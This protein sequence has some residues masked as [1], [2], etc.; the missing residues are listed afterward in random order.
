MTNGDISRIPRITESMFD[1]WA[2]NQ[3]LDA[4][5]SALAHSFAQLIH[6]MHEA[7]KCSCGL[8]SPTEGETN[9]LLRAAKLPP[10]LSIDEAIFRRLAD[11]PAEGIKYYF[12]HI[13]FIESAVRL[14]QSDLARRPRTRRPITQM[15]DDIVEAH[16]SIS[17][18][19]VTRA[20]ASR[21]GV[22]VDGSTFRLEDG[23]RCDSIEEKNIASR[24]SDAKKRLKNSG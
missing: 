8:V 2:S 1:E 14:R 10:P 24:V 21:C 11:N 4:S 18:K 20:L 19:D 17:A 23:E 5:S 7:I 13:E 6:D 22:T 16:P 12:E 3:P 15:I 9:N